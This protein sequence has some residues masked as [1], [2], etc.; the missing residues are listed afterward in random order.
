[1]T[2]ALLLKNFTGMHLFATSRNIFTSD[3][4][5]GYSGRHDVN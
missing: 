2:I 3:R 4:T 1:M 5:V